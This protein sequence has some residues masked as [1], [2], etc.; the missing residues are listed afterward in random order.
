MAS[1]PRCL[2]HPNDGPHEQVPRACQHHHERPHRDPLRG[3]RVQPHP[4]PAV[5]DLRLAARGHLAARH[6]HPRPGHL[7][8]E[9]R[10]HPPPHRRIRHRDLVV[11]AQPLRDRSH[12]DIGVQPALDPVPMRLDQRPRR[13]PGTGIIQSGKPFR[14]SLRP[15]LG[16]QWFSARFDTL[17]FRWRQILAD[18]LAIHPQRLPQLHL[19][20]TRLPMHVQ[21]DQI[22]HLDTSPRHQRPFVRRTLTDS[23]RTCVRG[24]H[25]AD[26]PP[27]VRNYLTAG[28]G[29]SV[30]DNP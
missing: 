20:A 24:P 28:V 16:G 2:V 10:C 17:R 26:T 6:R 1:A 12:R 9:M 15:L 13:C 29:N 5:V 3:G 4:Q 21:L 19:R 11:V 14:D 22:Q 25:P 7:L 30:T 8:S 18:R 27:R 23:E